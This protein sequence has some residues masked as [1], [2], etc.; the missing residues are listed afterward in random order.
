MMSLDSTGCANDV[1][2]LEVHSCD[3]GDPGDAAAGSERLAVMFK[4]GLVMFKAEFSPA[5]AV[6]PR[7]QVVRQ[8]AALATT[9]LPRRGTPEATALQIR[10]R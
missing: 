10:M 3:C 6:Q 4:A 2:V 1:S 8:P 9:R 5:T 7:E